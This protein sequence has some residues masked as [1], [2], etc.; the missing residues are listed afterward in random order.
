V[1]AEKNKPRDTVTGL[2]PLDT[3][4]DQKTTKTEK[5]KAYEELAAF[6]LKQYRKNVLQK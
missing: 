6:L 4:K 2:S 5:I 1:S 3:P